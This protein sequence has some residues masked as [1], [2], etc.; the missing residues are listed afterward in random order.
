M[1]YAKTLYSGDTLL[2]TDK[3]TIINA[4]EN[5][6]VDENALET[7]FE[8]HRFTDL[9]R[10]AEHKSDAGTNGTEWLAWKIGRR[11]K[12][13]TDPAAEVDKDLESKMKDKT[14]WYLPMP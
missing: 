6:I 4:V 1:D 9:I 13:V 5:L 12:N 14:N 3:E 11:N 2:V 7:A 10:F 8:G